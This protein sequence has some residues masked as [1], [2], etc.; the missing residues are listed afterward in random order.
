MPYRGGRTRLDGLDPTGTDTLVVVGGQGVDRARQDAD[1]V[2]W[3]AVAAAAARR[4][5]RRCIQYDPAPPCLA[6]EP[7]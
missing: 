6:D 3:V 5:V 7:V 2:P 4:A 1:L